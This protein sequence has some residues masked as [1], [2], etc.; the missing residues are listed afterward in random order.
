MKISNEEFV[1]E[2]MRFSCYGPLMQVF[3]IEA[4]RSYSEQVS[5]SV[6]ADNPRALIN[7]MTWHQ[8]GKDV[9]KALKENYEETK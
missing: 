4:L 3:V 9:Q 7:P 1:D 2:L 5:A 8:I 6:P